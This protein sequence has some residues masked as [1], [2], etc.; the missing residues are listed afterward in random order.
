MTLFLSIRNT[1]RYI[2]IEYILFVLCV[3]VFFRTC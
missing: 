2:M 3:K 1:K